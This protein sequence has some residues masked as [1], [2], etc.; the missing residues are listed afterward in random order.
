MRRLESERWVPDAGTRSRLGDAGIS[1]DAPATTAS[2]LC[3]PE[4]SS[5]A[6]ARVSPVLAGLESED[7]RVATETLRYAGYVDRQ[8]REAKR[9]AA[10]GARSIP[11]GFVY[12]GRAG[13][14]SELVEKLEAVRPETLGRASR[15]DGMTP[16]ALALLAAHLERGAAGAGS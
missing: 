11:E 12:R 16:A 14:S 10:A 13:L 7:R 4:T 5:E 15:I 3:R 8:R 9:V 6:L 2:L 1:I